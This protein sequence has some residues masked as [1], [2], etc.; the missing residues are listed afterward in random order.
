MVD[1]ATGKIRY[2]NAGHNQ[3]L[4]IRENG[5][6]F[7]LLGSSRVLGIT[8]D[9]HYEAYDAELHPGDMLAIFSDGV[10]EVR[11][12]DLIEEYGEERLAE[13]L[14]KR[15]RVPLTEIIT[16]LVDYLRKWSGEDGFAD[17]FTML[18]MRRL[19]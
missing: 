12:P 6:S 14:S 5:T 16:E 2:A 8:S 17:D 4:V 3:P 10:T 19:A 7:C 13:F 11:T 9:S 15:Q 1:P 18:I